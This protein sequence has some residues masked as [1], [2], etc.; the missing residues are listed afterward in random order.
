MS[1]FHHPLRG[2]GYDTNPLFLPPRARCSGVRLPDALLAVAQRP[3]RPSPVIAQSRTYVEMHTF[4][5]GSDKA[6]AAQARFLIGR[7]AG[8]VIV[9]SSPYPTNHVQPA[10]RVV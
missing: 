2:H 3:R 10:E 5:L 4:Q 6:R 1:P 7:V 9:I 8:R